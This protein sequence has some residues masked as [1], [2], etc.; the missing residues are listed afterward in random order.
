MPLFQRSGPLGN[1]DDV[2][3]QGSFPKPR[4]RKGPHAGAK[5]L[6]S[7]HRL[8]YCL[9]DFRVQS[10]EKIIGGDSQADS[11]EVSRES[12]GVI[13]NRGSRRRWVS[14]VSAGQH[15]H[16][17]GEIARGPGHGPG[18]IE[19][20]AEGVNSVAADPTVRRFEACCAAKRRGDPDG[21]PRIR[22]Q[23]E[24]NERSCQSGG[25]SPAGPPGDSVRVPGVPDRPVVRVQGGGAVGELMHVQLTDEDG[26]RRGQPFHHRGIEGGEK[27]PQDFGTAG[28]PNPPGEKEVF[29]GVRD[30]VERAQALS[31]KNFLFGAARSLHRLTGKEGQECV[32]PRVKRLDS[33]E[34]GPRHLDGGKFLPFEKAG[35]RRDCPILGV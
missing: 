22:A 32:D 12:T 20:P 26:A 27:V 30:A 15:V 11:F 13:G 18:V 10:F 31:Q 35:K 14:R 29:S 2:G 33:L 3:G 6:E 1:E 21:T 17:Q 9:A 25:R 16:N 4:N 34:A 28:G 23:R 5:P 7:A 24:G 8:P 19:R